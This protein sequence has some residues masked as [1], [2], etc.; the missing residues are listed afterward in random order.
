VNVWKLPP[1]SWLEVTPD[2]RTKQGCYWRMPEPREEAP[3]GYTRQ[4]AIE[5]IRTVFDEAVKLRMIAD[6]PLGAFLSGGIDSSLMVAS[7][8]RHPPPPVRTFSIGWDE[9]THNELPYATTVAKHYA[10]D[11]HEMIVRPNAI[12]LLPR[13]VAQF[14]EPFADASAIPTYLVSKF[15]AEHVTVALSGDGGAE[16]F[17]G[18]RAFLM[19]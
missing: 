8:P 14:D 6:V 3:S 12:E 15:A 18:S 11:H 10:T 17:G 2:G 1:A 7:M 13:L 9:R 19:T 5:E 4:D 16:L